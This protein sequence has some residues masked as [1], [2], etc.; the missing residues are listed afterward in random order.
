MGR[1]KQFGCSNVFQQCGILEQRRNPVDH[2]PDRHNDQ[3]SLLPGGCFRC[4]REYFDLGD[5]GD[6]PTEYKV[7]L[8]SKY[9]LFRH[10]ELWYG[11]IVGRQRLF[12]GEFHLDRHWA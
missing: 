12:G 5:L 7:R 9:Q 2:N 11:Y 1:Y 4:L 6:N 10:T 3:I 8:D